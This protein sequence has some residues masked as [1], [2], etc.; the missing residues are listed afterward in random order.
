MPL[1]F[2][3][4]FVALV[5]VLTASALRAQPYD[6]AVGLR[7]GYPLAVSYKQYIS[8]DGAFE[9]YGGVRTNSSF[10]RLV[11]SGAYQQHYSFGLDAELAPLSWYWGAGAS[12]YFYNYDDRLVDR[13]DYANVAAGINGYLG[14]EYAFTAV[15]IVLTLD[16][17]PSII[18]GNAFRGGFRGEHSGLGVRYILD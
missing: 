10:Q 6:R 4:L 7:V 16:W 2:R 11:V 14:L 3:S 18:L 5:L 17:V 1:A 9:V 13:N 8:S 12:M 15:P